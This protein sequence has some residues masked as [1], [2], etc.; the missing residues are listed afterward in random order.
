MDM[1]ETK[2]LH[3]ATEKATSEAANSH[4]YAV[5]S[6]PRQE[7]RALANLAQQGYDCYLPL[8]RTEKIDKRGLAIVQAPL[9]P[10]YLFIFLD[11]GPAGPGWG[12]IRS[13]LGVSRIVSFGNI[14]AKLPTTLVEALREQ[15]AHTVQQVERLFAAGETVK[16]A[17][18]AFA[19]LTGVYQMPSG[20]QRAMVLID[21]L[22]KL[23]R[24]EFPAASLR[25]TV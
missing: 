10:R 20:E 17:D 24:V 9:F 23:C 5:H 16:I 8:R 6:K 2:A 18:G 21:I 7:Q 22:S 12:P 15:S 11:S 4:W 25:K 13:T 3:Q 19:G 1:A 14:P